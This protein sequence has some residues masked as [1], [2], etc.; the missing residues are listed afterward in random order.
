VRSAWDL[1]VEVHQGDLRKG[2]TIPYVSH[3]WSVAALVLEH[4]GHDTQVAAALLHD[5]VEDGGGRRMLEEIKGLSSEVAYLVEHLSDSVVDTTR[6]EE[7]RL[8]NPE[9]WLPEVA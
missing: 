9:G 8:A 5:A 6:N 3:L 4:G 2:T 7:S 1:A